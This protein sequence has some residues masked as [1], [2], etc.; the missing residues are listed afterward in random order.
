LENQELKVKIQTLEEKTTCPQE[1]G[2]N[3]VVSENVEKIVNSM[4]VN[5]ETKSALE[6]SQEH[7]K[8]YD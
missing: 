4:P 2:D 3:F 5:E 7:T 8:R 6:S 1:K